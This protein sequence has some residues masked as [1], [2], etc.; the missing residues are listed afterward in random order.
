MPV[1]GRQPYDNP[2][3]QLAPGPQQP[4]ADHL[5]QNKTNHSNDALVQGA[6]A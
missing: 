4:A 3:K 6:A 2:D 1:P 5:L